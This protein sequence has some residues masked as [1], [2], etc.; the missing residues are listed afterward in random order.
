MI[1]RFSFFA[2]RDSQMI[3]R[4]LLTNLKL[5]VGEK[6]LRSRRA[7]RASTKS[8]EVQNHWIYTYNRIYNAKNA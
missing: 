5:F 1:L 4:K 6:Y 2:M 3:S 8:S 7:A